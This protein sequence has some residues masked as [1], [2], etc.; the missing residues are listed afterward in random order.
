M[1]K[2]TAVTC[3]ARPSESGDV[4][5]AE[6]SAE[7]LSAH[8]GLIEQMDGGIAPAEQ[9]EGHVLSFLGVFDAGV[10]GAWELVL[11]EAFGSTIRDVVHY[12]QWRA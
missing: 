4:S 3:R 2:P 6:G 11:D 10:V 8:L 5:E 7:L 9:P 12:T 1:P